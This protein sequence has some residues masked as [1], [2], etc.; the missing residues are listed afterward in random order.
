MRKTKKLRGVLSGDAL[1]QVS[2]TSKDVHDDD[3][4][5]LPLILKQDG[6]TSWAELDPEPGTPEAEEIPHEEVVAFIRAKYNFRS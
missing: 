6:F 5:E 1:I 4:D 2:E 3:S